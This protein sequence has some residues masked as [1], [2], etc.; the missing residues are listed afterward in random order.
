MCI[1]T[2]DLLYIIL[3]ERGP[4]AI[5]YKVASSPTQQRWATLHKEAYSIIYTVDKL[6]HLLA[7]TP[8]PFIIRTDHRSYTF[9]LYVPLWCSQFHKSVRRLH[10]THGFGYIRTM[11]DLPSIMCE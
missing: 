2:V 5:P 7:D 6:N 1:Y 9:R 11:C 3:F 10:H 8:T 4:V